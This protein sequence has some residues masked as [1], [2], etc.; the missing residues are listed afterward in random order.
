MESFKDKLEYLK[1]DEKDLPGHKDILIETCPTC[2]CNIK[3]YCPSG[4][5][6]NQSCPIGKQNICSTN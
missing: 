3:K 5:C 6:E 1:L 4:K 2:G